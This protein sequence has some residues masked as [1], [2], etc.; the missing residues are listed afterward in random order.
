MEPSDWLAITVL[1]V[2]AVMGTFGKHVVRGVGL[3]LVAVAFL[4]WI[5]SHF[6]LNAH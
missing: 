3:A 2:G 1:G 6:Y 5:I 4:G